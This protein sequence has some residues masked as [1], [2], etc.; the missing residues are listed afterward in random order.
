[1]TKAAA[2]A[3][4]IY[5]GGYD[6][7]GSLN[8]FDLPMGKEL[9]DVTCFLDQGRKYIP[10]FQGDALNVGGF[11]D[12]GVGGV[13]AILAALQYTETEVCVLVGGTAFESVAYGAT[14]FFNKYELSS[15]VDDAIVL[16]GSFQPGI[17]GAGVVDQ[18]IVLQAKATKSVDGEGT[19]HDGLAASSDGAVA[20]LQVFAC[21]AD[22]DLVVVIEDD[23]NDG[24][25]TPNTLITFTTANG[26]TSER[27]AVT[28]AVQ[29]YVRV[30][31][32]G[33][34]PWSASFAVVFRRI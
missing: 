9:K 8:K 19:G 1:M 2:Q 34:E 7:S 17:E 4:A 15:Q 32:N 14:L 26:I 33:V 5:V 6:I 29:R 3:S 16:S 18:G 13:D 25:L 21:G 28:G 24:F 23:D 10:L 12:N 20:Y 27:K 30:T 31:Y 22:D 11:F